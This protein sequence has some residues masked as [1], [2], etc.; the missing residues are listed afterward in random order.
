MNIPKYLMIRNYLAGKIVS[1]ELCVGGKLP[2]ESELAKSFNVN[3]HTIR[4]S[5][6]LLRLE[7]VIDR[8][9]RRG[10]VI[11]RVP[12][13]SEQTFVNYVVLHADEVAIK[14]RVAALEFLAAEF[15]RNHP[16]IE[17]RIVPILCQGP[18]FNPPIS[19]LSGMRGAIILEMDYVADYAFA[20]LLMDLSEFKDFSDVAMKIDGRLVRKTLSP[21]NTPCQH[22]LPVGMTSWMF[23]ANISLMSKLGYSPTVIPGSYEE[24]MRMARD[25]RE[26]FPKKDL[27]LLDREMFYSSSQSIM[28]YLPFMRKRFSEGGGGDVL[29]PLLDSSLVE[30]FIRKL[31][32]LY[33]ACGMREEG[34]ISLFSNS[35]ALFRLSATHFALLDPALGDARV[36]SYPLPVFSENS[37]GTVV[38]G[39]Y[40]GIVASS[41]KDRLTKETAWSFIKHLLSRDG[42]MRLLRM[43]SSLPAR[44]DLYAE[45]LASHTGV[46]RFFEY[47]L[48]YGEPSMDIPGN[49]VTHKIIL[50]TFHRA[51]ESPSRIRSVLRDGQ[52]LLDDYQVSGRSIRKIRNDVFFNA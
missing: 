1:G 14:P 42:Q 18:I 23:I 27:Y 48:K 17:V 28:R 26:R 25:V 52:M 4:K 2:P 41:V 24:L 21:D 34:T 15:E 45:V 3:R 46:A 47:A 29:P 39:A 51:L 49:A 22:A 12:S 36:Q 8:R 44:S 6:D 7:G 35:K 31:S 30:D 13:S 40:A 20:G 5:L 11:L 37:G 43:A 9:P 38:H 50:K 16:H 10:T 33:G 32:E 19:Y